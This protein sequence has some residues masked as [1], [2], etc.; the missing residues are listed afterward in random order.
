MRRCFARLLASWPALRFG[1]D[2]LSFGY[3]M[4][5]LIFYIA[6]TFFADERVTGSSVG[7]RVLAAIMYYLLLT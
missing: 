3:N 4:V 6:F 7:C 2:P 5:L 1:V